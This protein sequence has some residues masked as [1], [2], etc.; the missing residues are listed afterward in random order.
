MEFSERYLQ[1]IKDCTSK[2]LVSKLLRTSTD[3][4]NNKYILWTNSFCFGLTSVLLLLFFL[5]HRGKSFWSQ[6]VTGNRFFLYMCHDT[7]CVSEKCLYSKR[8][9]CGIFLFFLFC[10][11]SPISTL[12]PVY[13]V[14]FYTILSIIRL[15][16][17]K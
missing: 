15:G 16:I 3:C 2:S 14:T 5:L 13:S 10:V 11:S 6:E 9:R 7:K 1:Q 4:V 12:N 17:Q 8:E